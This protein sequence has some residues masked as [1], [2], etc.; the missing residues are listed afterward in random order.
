VKNRT[1][2]EVFEEGKGP[3][4][5]I[6]E[7]DDLMMAIKKSTITRNGI[8]FLNADY[9]DDNL[10]GLRDEVLIR[11]SLFDLS[12]VKIYTTRGEFLCTAKRVPSVHPMAYYLGDPK[13]LEEF[14]QQIS[15]KNRVRKRTMQL[16]KDTLKLLDQD[17]KAIDTALPWQQ[18]VE[19]CPRMIEKMEKENISLPAIEARIPIEAIR[20]EQRGLSNELMAESIE[21]SKPFFREMYERYEYLLVNG[22]N[23]EED[24][25]WVED[26]KKTEEYRMLYEVIPA[27]QVCHDK[28]RNF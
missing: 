1:V 27:Q 2:G 5:D 15:L 10:Y 4:V 7:L 12:Q 22:I 13:D 21:S 18:I 28:A 26:Y 24:R 16:T 14:K 17:K 20:T 11:Y 9:Y 19:V 6:S 25:R 3:G 8:R 23:S